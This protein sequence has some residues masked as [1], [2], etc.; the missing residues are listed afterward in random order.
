MT[1][2]SDNNWIVAH[3]TL[4]ALLMISWLYIPA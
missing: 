2:T 4:V 1:W 3:S